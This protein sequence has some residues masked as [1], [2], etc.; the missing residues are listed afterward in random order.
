M[1]ELHTL[2]LNIRKRREV[3]LSLLNDEQL[4]DYGLLF[5]S[6]PHAWPTEGELI[7]VPY[8]H[9]NWEKMI[10]ST[11]SQ[12]RWKIRSMLWVRS[13]LEAEQIPIDSPDITAVELR[14]PGARIFVASI[15]VPCQN[16]E[17][18]ARTTELIRKA[19][20]E[21][22][23]RRGAIEIILAGDFNRHNPLW[24]G[25]RVSVQRQG[26]AEPILALIEELGLLSLLPR[27]TKTWQNGERESTIDLL[28]ASEVLAENYLQCRVHE[29]EHGSDHRAIEAR[30]DFDL[31]EADRK[32]RLLLK[33][34]P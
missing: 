33:N 23:A 4:K 9:P 22:Q 19:I 32:P 21:L 3:Q 16:Q 17:A 30:F 5:I 7:T 31:P 20:A 2:Q 11:L 18:L 12:E 24:G 25:D 15:Y 34:A 8:R 14:I 27:G 1:I 13:D 10:P 26:E 28:L 29:T 6:E